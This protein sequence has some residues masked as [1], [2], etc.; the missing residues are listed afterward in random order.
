M[1]TEKMH[2]EMRLL[3]SRAVHV[4]LRTPMAK[5]RGTEGEHDAEEIPPPSVA[6]SVGV[7]AAT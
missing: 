2:V 5:E 1:F 6:V 3:V 4:M 7:Y